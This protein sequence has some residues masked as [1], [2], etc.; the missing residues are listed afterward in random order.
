MTKIATTLAL[1]TA[2]WLAGPARSERLDPAAVYVIDG[3]TISLN[4][5]SVRLVGFDTPETH[6]PECAYERA[7]AERATHRLEEL[8]RSGAVIELLVLPGLDKYDR[9]LGRLLVANRDVG[10]ILTAEGFARPYDGGHREG[11]CG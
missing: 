4:G 5:R 11:W 2:C 10:E 1:I 7:L 3:D 8:V 6:E 9:R